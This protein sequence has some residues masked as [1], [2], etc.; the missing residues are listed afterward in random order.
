MTHLRIQPTA[1]AAVATRPGQRRGG[2]GW[3]AHAALV[4]LVLALAWVPTIGRLHQI[5]HAQPLAQIHTGHGP[6]AVVEHASA[7]APGLLGGFLSSHSLVDCLLLDQL[8]LGDTLHSA[9]PAL[10]PSLPALAPVATH[11]ERVQARHVALFQA[12]GPPAL[13]G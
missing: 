13:R 1:L 2:R 6:L 11:A 10:L 4:W 9:A 3:A 8:A 12:R 5:A 7:H